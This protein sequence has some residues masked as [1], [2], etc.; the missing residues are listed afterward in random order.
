M[1]WIQS[2]HCH[3]HC[4]CLSLLLVHI[5]IAA[6]VIAH[7]HAISK[8]PFN[9][10]CLC[11][12]VTVRFQ[13]QKLP[14]NHVTFNSCDLWNARHICY[15]LQTVKSTAL[16]LQMTDHWNPQHKCSKCT[17]ME[18][19]IYIHMTVVN[20]HKQMNLASDLICAANNCIAEI[21]APV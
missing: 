21:S 4:H 12:A 20:L 3:C 19:N 13:Q 16:Q 8:M 5:I 17:Q 15:K 6:M 9:T 14:W 1:A 7:F 10:P 11:S 18:K 2:K